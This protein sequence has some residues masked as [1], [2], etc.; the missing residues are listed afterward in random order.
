MRKGVILAINDLYLTLLTPE[1][2][3]LRARKFRQDYQIGEEIDFF[4]ELEID[5]R[6]KFSAPFFTSLKARSFILVA[7]LLLMMAAVLPIYQEGQVY[8]YMSIDVNPSIEM[9]VNDE[10]KVL[11]INGYNPEG[12]QIITEIEDWRKKDAAIVAKMILDK[13]EDHG[14][15]TNQNAVIIATV[16]K[17]KAR[18]SADQKLEQK[19]AEIKQTTAEE[20]LNLKVVEATNDDREKAV[21]QGITA[22]VYKEKNITPA[23]EPAAAPPVNEQKAQPK[24]AQ[25]SQVQQPIRKEPERELKKQEAPGQE[26]KVKPVLPKGSSDVKQQGNPVVE[27]INEKKNSES[28]G[29]SNQKSHP[30]QNGGIKPDLHLEKYKPEIKRNVIENKNSVQRE[31]GKRIGNLIKK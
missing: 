6:K 28:N 14:Y 24:A 7:A 8:A 12:K 26:K 15:F 4:P 25:E 22:G 21:K 29:N 16:H 18:K 9:A 2:E 5:K 17:S 27:K 20:N 30:V 3:F 13:I 31:T 19:V 11:E 23:K 1:G 10:L